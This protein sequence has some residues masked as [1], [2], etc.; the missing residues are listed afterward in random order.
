MNIVNLAGLSFSSY[1]S[2]TVNNHQWN[3]IAVLRGFRTK[4]MPSMHK[5]VEIVLIIN[6]GLNEDSTFRVFV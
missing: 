1:K 5:L 4:K 2:A 6:S 3:L